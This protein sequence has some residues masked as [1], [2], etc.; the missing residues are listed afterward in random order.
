[1]DDKE[2]V[3]LILSAS[4]TILL[5]SIGLVLFLV[6][7][8]R[9]KSRNLRQQYL[10]EEQ[11]KKELFAA[12]IEIKDQVLQHVG[13]ELHD[14]IGQLLTVARIHIK[15]LVKINDNEKL[16]E[17]N[18]I[19]ATALDELRKLSKT[20]ISGGYERDAPL[21]ELIEQEMNMIEKTGVIKAY[22]HIEGKEYKLGA[23]YEIFCFRI[24]Q[25]FVSNA[26][27]YSGCE[28]LFFELQY[29]PD[30]FIFT[31]RDDGK[32]FD[33]VNITRGNG[34]NNIENRAKMIG[35]TYQLISQENKGTKLTFQ[36]KP[37]N[38]TNDT[39]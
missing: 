12:Q 32:G 33:T 27:K 16:A 10:L 34:L 5:V 26:L 1:M 37:N 2:I 24:L 19:T 36:L 6:F 21:P 23:D 28:N 7:F 11:Y 29:L 8:I 13:R 30:L 17:V 38:K 20:L 4:I 39:V 35:A 31:L 25:E 15:G 3:F 9:T 22:L 18:N 14:N